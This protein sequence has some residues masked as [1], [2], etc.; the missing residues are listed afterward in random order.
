MHFPMKKIIFNVLLTLLLSASSI[1]QVAINTDG[2]LPDNSAML[3]VKSTNKGLLPPRMTST[4]RIAI[5]SPAIGLVVYDTDLN[6]LFLRTATGWVPLSTSSSS[7]GLN[8]NGGTMPGT[9]FIGTTDD[10]DLVFK[11]G[12]AV[13][14]RISNETNF[15]YNTSL[16]NYASP[17]NGGNDNTAFGDNALYS[18]MIGSFNTAIGSL[19][20]WYSTG[21][22]NTALGYQAGGSN[23]TGQNNTYVGYDAGSIGPSALTNA[24]AIGANT[25]VTQSN[26][27]VLGNNVNVGIG[28]TAPTTKL[29]VLGEV[30]TS[31]ST[32]YGFHS[33]MNTGES[34]GYG[35][36]FK[37]STSNGRSFGVYG[38]ANYTGINNQQTNYAGYFRSNSTSQDGY[39]IYA[40]A[41]SSNPIAVPFTTTEFGVYGT[42]DIMGIIGKSYGV[43]GVAYGGE[44][45]YGIYG[46]AANAITKWAGYFEG[47]VMVTN[48]MQIQGGNPGLGKVLTS[49]AT[50]N[51]SW[52]SAASLLPAG[53]SGQTLRHNGTTWVANSILSNDGVNIGI[54]TSTPANKLEVADGGIS[55]YNTTDSKRFVMNYDQTGHYFYID[56]YGAG[57]QFTILNGGNV[58][59][60]TTSPAAKLDVN[61]SF[62]LFNGTQAA[63]RVLTSDANGLATWQT[64]S[65]TGHYIGESYGGGIVFYVYD[66]GRH[67]LIAATVDQSTGIRW[68]GGS[69]TN[70]R[71]RADGVGAGLKNTAIII[72]N[73]GN[74]D[75]VAFAATVCNE[76][77]VTVAGITYGDWY[78]PSKQELDLLYQ[79]K[80]AVSNLVN[81]GYWSS[82]ESDNNNAWAENFLDRVQ[83]TI[84]KNVSY[85]VRAIRAF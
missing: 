36:Y 64:P 60:G 48:T 9:N 68:Y 73:Q 40:E 42:G 23:S 83:V 67:G 12:N 29:E 32:T 75:G 25:S 38:E 21:T 62:K 56:E 1:A 74:V 44:A 51:A 16:G 55:L 50:G 27:L 79:Q 4:Q 37:H 82:S 13:S 26:S 30:K 2:S 66:N 14:G 31:G 3:D 71:A 61:G 80:A 84:T 59:I 7:W 45:A 39:G 35:G 47:N 72:A 53:T 22:N 54:G 33:D 58:G 85:Y 52:Q 24:T 19:A 69:Y 8:G 18:N 41:R 46:Y 76:Y 57:R 49:D 63:G 5:L 10:K 65:G 77:S 34:D 15:H 81:I 11:V 70:T 78:L 17:S 28:T 43:K 20:L 6:S